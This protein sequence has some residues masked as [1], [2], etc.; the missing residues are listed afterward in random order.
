[1]VA[2]VVE[3]FKVSVETLEPFDWISSV[4]ALLQDFFEQPELEL[5]SEADDSS[6]SGDD[7][8]LGD[9]LFSTDCLRSDFF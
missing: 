1:M 4:P 2:V 6:A 3:L 5:T 9:G 7:D 8:Q